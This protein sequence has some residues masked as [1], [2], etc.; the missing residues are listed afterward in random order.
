MDKPGTSFY[1][2]LATN[3]HPTIYSWENECQVCYPKHSPGGFGPCQRCYT[4][5]L[6]RSRIGTEHYGLPR[7]FEEAH[8]EQIPGVPIHVPV[9]LPE[10]YVCIVPCIEC[11]KRNNFVWGEE[12][13]DENN[14]TPIDCNG[15]NEEL[16]IENE[17]SNHD[18]CIYLIKQKVEDHY[19]HNDGNP[20]IIQFIDYVK[21]TL[22]NRI[23][24][25]NYLQHMSDVWLEFIISIEPENTT[26]QNF[27]RSCEKINDF[28]N[29]YQIIQNR[30]E[31]EINIE[32]IENIPEN[33]NTG[34]IVNIQGLCRN[35]IDILDS[36]MSYDD[37]DSILNEENYRNLMD[38]FQKIYNS[39]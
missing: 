7:N 24:L 14:S 22:E 26:V 30:I 13:I 8:L 5:G 39:S 36:V 10:N 17:F 31:R 3:L 1:S 19:I 2:E 4:K 33:N 34:E 9:R 12:M 29:T 38:I 23:D 15:V 25:Q 28:Q 11:A 18:L 27:L 6:W 32:P 16:I 37:M 21:N 35:G 20:D